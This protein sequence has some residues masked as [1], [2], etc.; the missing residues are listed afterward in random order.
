MCTNLE[1]LELTPHQ[2][3]L[4]RAVVQRHAYFKWLDAGCP[5]GRQLEFWGEAEREWIERDYVPQRYSLEIEEHA[6]NGQCKATDDS[7]VMT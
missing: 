7:R 5:E 4:T 1:T 2:L 3:E 6:A